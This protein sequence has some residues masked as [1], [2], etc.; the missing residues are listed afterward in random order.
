MG[1]PQPQPCNRSCWPTSQA[2]TGLVLSGSGQALKPLCEP[3]CAVVTD[4]AQEQKEDATT[5]GGNGT[6]TIAE[7]LQAEQRRAE[8]LPYLSLRPL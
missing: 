4:T 7:Q 2:C 3:C 6:M 1:A 8:V 5:N